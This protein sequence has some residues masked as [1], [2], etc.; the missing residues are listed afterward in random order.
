MTALILPDRRRVHPRALDLGPPE[1]PPTFGLY[2]LVKPP[3][4]TDW[5]QRWAAISWASQR[6]KDEADFV[7]AVRDAW[8]RSAVAGERVEVACKVG[9][10]GTALALAV[11]ARLSGTPADEAAD[12]VRTGH[13]RRAFTSRGDRRWVEQLAL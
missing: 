13:S 8:A 12:W 1:E 6:P 5:P 4:T 7:A 11:M 3:P 10:A 2:L 9:H